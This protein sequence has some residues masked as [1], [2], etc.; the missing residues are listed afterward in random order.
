MDDINHLNDDVYFDA[1]LSI[2]VTHFISFEQKYNFLLTIQKKLKQDGVF[3]TFDL[4][5]IITQKEKETLRHLCEI[6]GLTPEQTV[7]MLT[8]LD[9]V[10]FPLSE[11][12][13]YQLLRNADFKDF[14]RFTQIVCYQGF[15]A[16]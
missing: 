6:N 12:L 9:H 7:V 13:T 3:I 5:Q 16:Q 14:K 8:R 10:F 1:V 2:L 11:E 4:T 15:I